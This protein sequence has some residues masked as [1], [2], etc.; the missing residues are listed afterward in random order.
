MGVGEAKLLSPQIPRSW[1]TLNPGLGTWPP[2]PKPPI[3]PHTCF[4]W[5]EP[6]GRGRAG[7]RPPRG[8]LPNRP[9]P[10]RG[11]GEPDGSVVLCF[12]LLPVLPWCVAM[13]MTPGMTGRGHTSSKPRILRVHHRPHLLRT[14]TPQPPAPR[15]FRECSMSLMDRHEVQRVR[16]SPLLTRSTLHRHSTP[17]GHPVCP[18]GPPSRLRS[19]LPTVR[20]ALGFCCVPEP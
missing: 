14:P 7:L 4:A 13:V 17:P 12:L 11:H 8:L 20:S 3:A 2:L 18:R 16:P 10:S 1:V 9:A 6:G 19:R 15:P 5:S